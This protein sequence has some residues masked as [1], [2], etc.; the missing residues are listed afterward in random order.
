[1]DLDCDLENV[2]DMYNLTKNSRQVIPL[3]YD[4]KISAPYSFYTP[5]L[6]LPPP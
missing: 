6:P 2:N 3:K 4:P 1:M 5:F